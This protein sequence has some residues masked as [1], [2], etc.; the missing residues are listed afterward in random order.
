MSQP[1]RIF[2]PNRRLAARRR[3]L[4]LQ[5]QPDAARY[6]LD[7]MVEDVLERLAFVRAE[8]QRAL[9]VGDWSGALAKTLRAQGA[10]VVEADPAGLRG[11]MVLDEE[12]PYLLRDF[13]LIVS[14]GTLDTVNDLPGAL[15]HMRQALAP[16]GLMIASFAGA[17]SLPTLRAIMLTAD[18]ER[19]AA[20][21]H[22]M[23][24]VRAGAQLLQRAGFADPVS[25]GRSLKVRFRSLAGLV[26]DV[27]AQGWGGV[28]TQ[29]GPPIGKAAYVRALAA[30]ADSA[31]EGRVTEV[32][33][34]VTLS[35]WKK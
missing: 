21:M 25:D 11:V 14:L 26:G 31:E 1:P 8:P 4:A 5:N 9:V 6:L 23:V 17:G 15:I 18:G 20:R 29:G 33:E 34:I 13:D 32:F 16:G 12:Q 28:L 35:G 3:A 30:F 27:R 10:E 2:A 24:D 22:P 7:D 19:P